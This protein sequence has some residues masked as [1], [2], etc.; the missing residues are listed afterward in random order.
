R[1]VEELS[2]ARS[3]L[4]EA[5]LTKQDIRD[6]SREWGLPT[7]DKPSAA[8]LSSRIA[9]GLPITAKRLY[10]VEQAEAVIKKY[11]RGQVRVRHHGDLARIEVERAEVAK[12]V[13]PEAAREI[14]K[15]LKEVGFTFVTVDLA[16]YRTGSMNAALK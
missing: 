11:C 12:I 8:C 2:I 7:W 6:I 9:Y 4:L 15:V 1:A 3:P 5:G 10:Q 14:E 13:E 16:G